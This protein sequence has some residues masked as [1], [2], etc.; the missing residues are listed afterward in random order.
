MEATDTMEQAV[1]SLLDIEPEQT[2]EIETDEVETDE[3]ETDEVEVEEIDTDEDEDEGEEPDSDEDDEDEDTDADEKPKLHKVKV[4]G[5]EREVTLDELKRGYSGQQKVQ[6]GMQQAAEVRKQ[7]EGLYQTLQSERQQFLATVQQMQQQGIVT[8]PKAPDMSML[9]N[10]PIGYMQEKAAYDV[11]MQEFQGQQ[12][13]IQMEQARAQQLQESARQVQLQ[14]QVKALV[15][16]IPEFA[17]PEK[18][19]NLK[20]ELLDYGMSKGLSAEELQATTN[21]AYVD[22]LYDAYRFRQ[23]QSGTAKA[24]KKPESSRN[25]KPKPRRSE[26]Q[27]IVQ[28]RKMQAAKKSGKPESF[29]D[30]L[31]E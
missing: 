30:F 5:E 31:L 4:D 10:D 25:V 16:R 6:K 22:I 23:L 21:A 9:E 19:A 14:E 17:N 11:K 3:V 20:K 2:E 13:Q 1:N 12:R 7:A 24:K 8:P 15:Q 28:Q 27:K 26:P 29:I 18:A